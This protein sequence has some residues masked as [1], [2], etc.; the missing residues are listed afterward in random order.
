MPVS[1]APKLPAR[2]F[3]ALTPAA[4]R[5]SPIIPWSRLRAPD[6][7]ELAVYRLAPPGTAR[8]SLL[9]GHANGFA[10]GSYG[11]LL[12]NLCRDFDLWAWDVRGHGASTLP[13]GVPIVEAMTLDQLARDAALVCAEVLRV[14]GEPPHI[15]AHSLS[16]VALLLAGLS[17]TPWRSATLFEPPLVTPA[18]AEADTARENLAR[19]IARTLKRR[20]I[21]P[22]PHEFGARLRLHPSY[23]RI[24][25]DVLTDHARA[26]LRPDEENWELRCA[27][28]TEAAVYAAV[29]DPHPFLS[30]EQ[31]KAPVNFVRSDEPDESGENWVQGVQPS[32]AAATHG[33]L[34]TLPC[35]THFLPLENPIGCATLIR[36]TILKSA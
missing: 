12:S 32:A 25:D 33:W 3:A 1:S 19:R 6:G 27:P 34:E 15:A 18:T 20:R 29:F 7:A 28:E 36:H 13:L 8:P 35:T 24:P 4:A 22:G 14:R 17:C 23:A 26:L 21:W 16:G 30:R 2:P 31:I 9:W 10:V 11:A 5:H